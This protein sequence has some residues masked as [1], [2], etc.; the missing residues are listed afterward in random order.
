RRQAQ[1][2]CAKSSVPPNIIAALSAKTLSLNLAPTQRPR[3]KTLPPS[4]HPHSPP[5]GTYPRA[6][7]S[8]PSSAGRLAGLVA[9]ARG[10]TPDPIPNSAVKTLCADGTA[11]Q[12]AEE[13]VAAR[14]AN[15]PPTLPPHPLFI[16]PN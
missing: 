16:S 5:Q 1:P 10:Q 8:G 14:P 3:P 7:I 9:I 15:H 4:H 2:S 11:P 13:W 6:H 12:G